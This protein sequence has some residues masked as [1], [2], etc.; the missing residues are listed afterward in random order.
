M[1]RSSSLPVASRAQRDRGE[2]NRTVR[3]N[4][5]GGDSPSGWQQLGEIRSTLMNT[6]LFFEPKVLIEIWKGHVYAG[7]WW[8][9]CK[10][11]QSVLRP[12]CWHTTLLR[13]WRP[14]GAAEVFENHLEAWKELLTDMMNMLLHR[15][16]DVWGLV[17]V[18]LRVPPWRKSWTFGVPLELL[19]LCEVLQRMLAA[20]C[21]SISDEADVHDD[22]FHISWN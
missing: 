16:A 14:L 10:P 6:Q 7:I 15:Q 11:P 22:E 1:Q 8:H 17:P 19:P 2:R 12:E 18:W 20:L 4:G 21:R 3:T 5:A 13:C 9:P